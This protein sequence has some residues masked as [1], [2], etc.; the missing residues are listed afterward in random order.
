MNILHVTFFALMSG[1][2]TQLVEVINHYPDKTAHHTICCEAGIYEGFRE[3]LAPALQEGRV[4]L[5]PGDG[6]K[7]VDHVKA[8]NAD[9]VHISD[10]CFMKDAY[11]SYL[12]TGI[13]FLTVFQTSPIFECSQLNKPLLGLMNEDNMPLCSVSYYSTLKYQLFLQKNNINY[14]NFFTLWNGMSLEKFTASP[15]ARKQVRDEYGIPE[16]ALL[17]GWAGRICA[18]KRPDWLIAAVQKLRARGHNVYGMLA[19]GSWWNDDGLNVV[20]EV[21]VAWGVADYVKFTG[22]QNDMVRYYSAFDIFAHPCKE[23]S[24]GIVLAEALAC[25]LPVVMCTPYSP[26]GGSSDGYGIVTNG[27][28]GLVAY[29]PDEKKQFELFYASLELLVTH[30]IFRDQFATVARESVK[31]FDMGIIAAEYERVFSALARTDCT[32]QLNRL[33]AAKA[34]LDHASVEA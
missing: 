22:F 8:T 25:N 5:R 10:A 9:V 4:T 16:D 18:V 7:I 13:P 28:N 12:E 24:F 34:L 21:A 17:I 11:Y 14:K 6:T 27:I 2:G 15:V 20:R 23:E 1:V 19:G 31:K 32:P 30:K 33:V 26:T 29:D 3:M